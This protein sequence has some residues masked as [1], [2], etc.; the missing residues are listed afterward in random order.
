MPTLH[1]L[2]GEVFDN[3]TII[4]RLGSSK[5]GRVTWVCQCI[6]GSMLTL[7]SQQLQRIK[8]LSCGCHKKTV[9]KIRKYRKFNNNHKPVKRKK[10]YTAWANILSR[11]RNPNATGH[12][13]VKKQSITFD[14]RWLSFDEFYKDVG[15]PPSSEHI[16]ERIDRTKGF[17][18]ENYHW[19]HKNQ[20][21]WDRIDTRMLSCNGFTYSIYEWAELT[22]LSPNC[23]SMRLLRGWPINRALGFI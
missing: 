14:E 17:Y 13:S 7:D 12:K 20:K 22:N 10:V 5:I 2:T 3:I 18:K 11:C 9:E 1:D 21:Q 8:Y 23:I 4:K 15:E 6:C 19:I 16:L